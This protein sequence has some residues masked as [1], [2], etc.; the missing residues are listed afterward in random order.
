MVAGL[1]FVV[2]GRFVVAAGR[3]ALVTR[4]FDTVVFFVA[5]L[6]DVG[7]GDVLTDTR[8]ECLVRCFTTFFGAASAIEPSTNMVTSATTS[9]FIVLRIIEPPLFSTLAGSLVSP[10]DFYSTF[11]LSLSIFAP[12]TF[13]Q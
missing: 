6:A 7:G 4:R 2:V 10:F 8:V 13:L 1:R 12:S 9:I 11:Y 3:L 5:V